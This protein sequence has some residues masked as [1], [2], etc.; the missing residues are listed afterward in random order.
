M[1][2]PIA[3]PRDPVVV[4]VIV[5]VVVVVVVKQQGKMLSLFEEYGAEIQKSKKQICIITAH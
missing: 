4:V 3:P 2:Q 5:V 1:P